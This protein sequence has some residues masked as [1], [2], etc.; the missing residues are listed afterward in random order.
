MGDVGSKLLDA[1]EREN[2]ED[3]QKILAQHPN[4]D[5]LNKPFD[6]KTKMTPLL[7]TVWRGNKPI[8]EWMLE[9]GA[10]VNIKSSLASLV[11]DG[12]TALIWAA[13]RSREELLVLLLNKGADITL[14]D[15]FGFTAL[16]Q[17][18][19]HG[20]YKEALLLKRAVDTH[21]AGIKT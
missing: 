12:N 4:Q 10:N 18:I 21:D 5:L 3:I 9:N 19:I 16:D 7:R 14:C 17:A 20:N 13:I 15:K 11:K 1:V 8:T 2:L 6:S